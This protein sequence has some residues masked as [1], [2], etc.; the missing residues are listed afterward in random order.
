MQLNDLVVITKKPQGRQLPDQVIGRR[1]RVVKLHKYNNVDVVLLEPF[2]GF[3]TI[4]LMPVSAIEKI[5]TENKPEQAI[6]K[7]IDQEFRKISDIIKETTDPDARMRLHAR[8][9]T[10]IPFKS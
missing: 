1:A 9:A 5:D 2:H 10:L 3:S 4:S 6:M 7:R 8:R